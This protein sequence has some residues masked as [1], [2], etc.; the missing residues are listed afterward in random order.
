MFP[1]TRSICL[2]R[3]PGHKQFLLQMKD[4]V[5]PAF[6]LAYFPVICGFYLSSSLDPS[7]SEEY[8]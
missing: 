7:I 4:G 2:I 5:S 3:E 1:A 6:D 8:F